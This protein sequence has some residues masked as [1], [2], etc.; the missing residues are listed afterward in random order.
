MA[1]RGVEAAKNLPSSGIL[2]CLRAPTVA[3]ESENGSAWCGGGR[4][5]PTTSGVH[6]WMIAGACLPLLR[7]SPRTAPHCVAAAGK[8]PTLFG[9]GVDKFVGVPPSIPCGSTRALAKRS[10]RKP[11]SDSRGPVTSLLLEGAIEEP[12]AAVS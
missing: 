1:P 4:Q 12:I 3:G 11:S 7:V 2:A 5:A 9:P 8:H 10:G 6:T